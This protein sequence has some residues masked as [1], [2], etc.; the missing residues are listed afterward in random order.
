MARYTEI[1]GLSELRIALAADIGTMFGAGIA[2]EDVL[3]T[4]G[5]NQAYAWRHWR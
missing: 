4:A 1:E 3:I 5:C 2:A